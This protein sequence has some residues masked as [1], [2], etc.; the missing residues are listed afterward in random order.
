[1]SSNRKC[2]VSNCKSRDLQDFSF[3]YIPVDTNLALQW[4]EAI[5]PFSDVEDLSEYSTIC[6]SHFKHED[7]IVSSKKRTLRAGAIPSRFLNSNTEFTESTEFPGSCIFNNVFDCATQTLR[8]SA[9]IESLEYTNRCLKQK[10]KQLQLR[11]DKLKETVERE[12]QEKSLC[13]EWEQLKQIKNDAKNLNPKA[14]LI[15]DQIQNYNKKK[16]KWSETTIRYC[17]AWRFCSPRGYEFPRND[18]LKLPCKTTLRKYFGSENKHLIKERLTSEIKNLNISERV[19]SLIV[20]DMAVKESIRYSKAEDRIF[21]L[22]TLPKVNTIT[23]KPVIAN[24]LLC[25]I[26]H[27]IS[28]KYVTPASYY[29]HKK[30]SSTELHKLALEVLKLLAECQFMV[31]RIVEETFWKWLPSNLH[32]TSFQCWFKTF[33]QF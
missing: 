12:K 9:Q 30:L 3:H 23:K 27:G 7:F 15:L 18:F 2:C 32:S 24:Q 33:F 28:T 13:K 29:F 1:M 16:P 31:V 26:I 10:L 11:Y 22:E 19:C 4:K 20:D 5:A 8:T 17:I 6:S 25:F 21:G 14:I